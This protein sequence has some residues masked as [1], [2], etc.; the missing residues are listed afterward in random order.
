MADDRTAAER[1]PVAHATHIVRRRFGQTARNGQPCERH[2]AA[3]QVRTP[4]PLPVRYRDPDAAGRASQD[5]RHHAMNGGGCRPPERP[6]AEREVWLM[7]HDLDAVSAARSLPKPQTEAH[8]QRSIAK[9]VRHPLNEQ[10]AG[11]RKAIEQQI[12]CAQI[13]P[14]DASQ[15]GMNG[16]AVGRRL[17]RGVADTTHARHHRSR[18]ILQ[19]RPDSS[20]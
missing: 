3:Q 7:H 9:S 5:H 13:A 11:R 15:R 20:R 19:R 6:A 14:R 2:I 12:D 10:A 8:V 16:H 1:V 17:P 18:P 4:S